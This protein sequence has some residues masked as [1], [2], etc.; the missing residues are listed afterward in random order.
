[1]RSLRVWSP[2]S[3][4]SGHAVGCIIAPCVCWVVSAVLHPALHDVCGFRAVSSI[5][6]CHPLCRASV[7]CAC[8]WWLKDPTRAQREAVERRGEVMLLVNEL[9]TL[10]EQLTK[11][12][13]ADEQEAKAKEV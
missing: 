4:S 7:M 1:M 6:L 11:L 10:S 13:Q 12:Q 8:R 9:S 3:S 5:L 2:V